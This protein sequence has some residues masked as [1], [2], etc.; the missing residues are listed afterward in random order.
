MF[1]QTLTVALVLVLVLSLTPLMAEQAL[2]DDP[3]TYT[4]HE[5]APGVWSGVRENGPQAPVMGTSTFVVGDDGVVV[6]D[7]GGAPLMSE[8]LMKKVAEVTNQPITHVV[9]S[10]WHGDHHFG[11]W[12]IIEEFPGVQVISH[13]FTRAATLGAPMDYIKDSGTAIERFAVSANER[14]ATGLERDGETPLSEDVLDYYRYVLEHKDLLDSQFKQYAATAARMTFEDKMTIYTGTREIQL[15]HVGDGNT[16]GDVIMWLPQEKIVATGDIVVL[17]TPYAFNVYPDRWRDTLLAI[18]ELEYEIL[19]PGHGE[20]Q[21]SKDFTNLMIEVLDSIIEQTDQFIE[22]GLTQEE[23]EARYDYS[24][25][26]E[27]FTGGDPYV[28]FFYNNYFTE[29]LSSAAYRA[30]KGEVLVKLEL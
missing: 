28:A 12:R 26:E 18:N 29:P 2:P 4:W 7:G 27:R 22:A 10:H 5:L 21:R 15:L 11:V 23:A 1:K 19:V 16:E 13:E 3:Y 17:P 24:V 20:I 6:F 30:A 9:I 25:F 14:L 8:R